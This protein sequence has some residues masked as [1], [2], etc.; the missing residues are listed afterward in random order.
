MFLFLSTAMPNG[1]PPKGSLVGILPAQI[2]FPEESNVTTKGD[3]LGS[4][5][6]YT[7]EEGSKSAAPKK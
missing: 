5:R 3:A 2:K 7:P 6:M 4:V 1:I